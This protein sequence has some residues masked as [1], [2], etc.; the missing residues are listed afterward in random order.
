MGQTLPLKSKGL[1]Y[2]LMLHAYMEASVGAHPCDRIEC[3]PET[4]ARFLELVSEH[5]IRPKENFPKLKCAYCR[6]EEDVTV[7]NCVGCGAPLVEATLPRRIGPP[8]FMGAELVYGSRL[9]PN[10]MRFVNSR[11]P[12]YSGQ[13]LV[14]V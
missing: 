11:C 6:R 8:R 4:M 14:G 1:T 3:S 2:A 12:Q 9:L 7:K 5:Y 13:L 10:E